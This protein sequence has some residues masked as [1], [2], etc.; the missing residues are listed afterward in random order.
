MS[1]LCEVEPCQLLATWP[2]QDSTQRLC[3]SHSCAWGA[4][5]AGFTDGSGKST[6]TSS[7]TRS[8]TPSS[9]EYRFNAFLTYARIDMLGAQKLVSRPGVL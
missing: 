9:W 2:R 3:T 4:Y 8:T 5:L 6:S 1:L 7:R